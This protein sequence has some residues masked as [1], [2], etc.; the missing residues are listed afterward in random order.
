MSNRKNRI[1]ASTLSPR[2]SKPKNLSKSKTSNNNTSQAGS[3]RLPGIEENAQS[4]SGNAPFVL[5][6]GMSTK[7]RQQ[8]H[9]ALSKCEKRRMKWIQRQCCV[10]PL[11][12]YMKPSIRVEATTAV[13]M[14]AQAELDFQE[15]LKQLCIA[16]LTVGDVWERAG[17]V[18][19]IAHTSSVENLLQ[20]KPRLEEIRSQLE[21]LRKSQEETD[22]N[23]SIRAKKDSTTKQ[24]RLLRQGTFDVKRDDQ[25]LTSSSRCSIGSSKIMSMANRSHPSSQCSLMRG[26]TPRPTNSTTCLFQNKSYT[27]VTDSKKV[28]RV[29]SLHASRTIELPKIIN[30]I[31]D[32]LLQL[33]LEQQQ[34]YKLENKE[35]YAYVVTITPNTDTE[36]SDVESIA[37]S[38]IHPNTSRSAI[39]N[40]TTPSVSNSS[41]LDTDPAA[42]LGSQRIKTQPPPIQPKSRSFL[43][44]SSRILKKIKN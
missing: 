22:R 42:H 14:E 6:D 39:C 13:E 9:L 12:K 20:N 27:L 11:L 24:P 10:L 33:P 43:K 44:M 38:S 26:V 4:E 28:S 16:E 31:G 7:S 2:G 18:T 23:L 36:T 21:Q 32:L 3:T 17:A 25:L 41:L 30:K 1:D 37:T 35:S 5:V 8:L 40:S 34:K 15:D 19:P 29:P